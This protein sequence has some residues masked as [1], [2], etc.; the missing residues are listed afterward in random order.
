MDSYGVGRSS[1]RFKALGRLASLTAADSDANKNDQQKIFDSLKHGGFLFREKKTPA[2]NGNKTKALS[3]GNGHIHN[4]PMAS[5]EL[6]VLLALADSVQQLTDASYSVKLLDQL[7]L[8]LVESYHQQLASTAFTRV[9]TPSPWEVLTLKLTLAIIDI[10]EKFTELR[11]LA[12][13]Y[14]NSYLENIKTAVSDE[15]IQRDNAQMFP[16][17]FSLQGFLSAILDRTVYH[18]SPDIQMKLIVSL[19]DIFYSNY[20]LHLE[21]CVSAML[22]VDNSNASDRVWTEYRA[23]YKAAGQILG[24]GLV[25]LRYIETLRHIAGLYLFPSTFKENKA[26][27]SYLDAL[28]DGKRLEQS[29]NELQAKAIKLCCDMA[30][31]EIT[32]L[33]EGTD[34]ADISSPR[35]RRLVFAIKASSLEVLCIATLF[36]LYDVADLMKFIARCLDD[37]DQIIDETLIIRILKIMSLLCR[38]DSDIGGSLTR[39]F[40]RLIVRYGATQSTIQVGTVCVAYALQFLSEDAVISTLY[41]MANVIV[42]IPDVQSDTQRSRSRQLERVTSMGSSIS[43]LSRSE[44]EKSII[45]ENVIH[46]LALVVEH[47]GDNKITALAVSVLSQKIG[48]VNSF[49]DRCIVTG[50]VNLAL[51]GTEKEFR[52][53]LKFYSRLISEAIAKGDV[54][55][56]DAIVDARVRIA[57]RLTQDHPFY[58]MYLKYLLD[59]IVSKGDVHDL[60]HHRIKSSTAIPAEEISCLITPMAKLLPTIQSG[61]PFKSDKVEMLTAFRN[62]WFNMVVHGYWLGSKLSTDKRVDLEVI[63]W[64]SPPLIAEDS[65]D[66]FESVIDVNI[67][68][69]LGASQHELND[70]RQ[71][72]LLAFAASTSATIELRALSYPK[73][74]FLSATVFLESLRASAGDCSKVQLY[75]IDPS[76][77]SGELLRLMSGIMSEVMKRYL[78]RVGQQPDVSTN[79]RISKQLRELLILCCH[80][81]RSVASAAMSS[82]QRIIDAIPSALC[83]RESLFTLLELLTLLWES[84][85]DEDVDQ[86]SPRSVFVSAKANI[87]LELSDSYAHRKAILKGLHEKA[88]TWV[89]SAID[90]TPLDVKGLLQSYLSEMDDLKAFGHLALGRSFAVEMGGRIPRSDNKLVS[91]EKKAEVRIDTLSDFLAQYT[92]RQVYRRS[93]N[94]EMGKIESDFRDIQATLLR[95]NERVSHRKFVSVAELK[96]GLLRAVAFSLSHEFYACELIHYIV[97]IPFGIFS[98]QSIKLGISLWLWILNEAPQY[99]SRV[100]SEIALGF[101][102]SI[103][104]KDGAFSKSHDLIPVLNGKMEYAPSS[105]EDIMHDATIAENKFL[106]HL[107]VVEMIA[108]NFQSSKFRSVHVFEIFERVLRVALLHMP[109]ASF[110]PF[111]RDIR[112]N[113]V[114]FALQ[115]LDSRDFSSQ[116]ASYFKS[117]VFN[118]ALSWF[119]SPPVYPFGGNKLK[120]KTEFRL[121]L[122]VFDS[123]KKIEITEPEKTLLMDLE[124]ELLLQFLENEVYGMAIWLDPLDF[125]PYR[126]LKTYI[127]KKSFEARPEMATAA[128]VIDPALAVSYAARFK[129]D[130]INEELKRLNEKFP[131]GF[132]NNANA[133]PY[134]IEGMVSKNKTAELKYLLYWAPANPIN[135]INYFMPEYSNNTLILQYA[136]RSLESHN[137]DVTFFYV[138]QIVQMLRNDNRGY[139]ERY[140]LETAKLSQL[141]AHQI[142][143]NMNSN[144]YRDEDATKPDPVKPTLDRVLE[145]MKAS[146]SGEDRDFYEREFEF[147]DEV[148][149]ISGK[150]KPYIK[151]TKAE[152][153]IKIDEEM[154]KIKVEVGVYLPSNPDGVVVGIDR[155]SGKPLQSHAKAPFMATFKIRKN[156]KK[157]APIDAEGEEETD[158]GAVE[159]VEQRL[160]AIFKVGDDC[161]QDMLAL[162]LIALFRRIFNASGLDLY[163]FPYRV[164]ATAPG[165]GVID[166]LPNS[167]SRDML[168]REAVNGLYEYFT[169]KHGGEDSIKFQHARNNFVQSMAAYSVISYL[170]QFKDRHNGNI[171]YDDD[172]HILHID[173]GFCFDIV[174]GGVKFEAAPFK[175]THEMVQVMGGSANTQ[176]Y[177][178][179]EE[180]CIKAFLSCRP[181][182]ENIIRCVVPMLESGLPCFKGE[183]TIR[184]LRER[185]VLEKSDKEAAVY[186][187]GLIK[188]SAESV[189]TRGYDEF[190]KMT[191]GIPY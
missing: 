10:G 119:A 7:G 18:N 25:R 22:S 94:S 60:N 32:T 41:T 178:W 90:K 62:A 168:G 148:T 117:L 159:T 64:N 101:E 40:P 158:T 141:F 53:I 81:I 105:K 107:Y 6:E 69:H 31:D 120:L 126:Q 160:S 123:V 138:P 56:K 185:F 48:R 15:S 16:L 114:L 1:I 112:F 98:K 19:H 175:L 80:R 83:N 153:K 92:W 77:R 29:P 154:L 99:Q 58:E 189:Y 166:V 89:Q 122:S 79:V 78:A 144:A 21:Q 169:S 20:S 68:L 96:E 102:W 177:H 86:Y 131:A 156:I 149:S 104:R 151:K 88:I 135:A 146:F 176:A 165:C 34:Y 164:I 70:Q 163:L 13:G 187:R 130:S 74:V 116:R 72:S 162:Q 172:G 125:V 17:T 173:F 100:L 167:I 5:K 84:C 152:K 190:Q 57:S 35:Q 118:A 115:L 37:E 61:K 110:H 133:L 50:L 9:M 54:E 59:D 170:L 129:T 186:M 33:E 161:R 174:P 36:D 82:T 171:M 23:K 44:E 39:I 3:N 24:P 14:I 128:W 140:I 179:F 65:S 188:K 67:I 26:T 124:K 52:Y 66:Q 93:G 27:N 75:L 45:F 76:L 191:N 143:W 8:Y 71:K 28:I 4:I 182:A 150:L 47:Y 113:I 111:V 137:V 132:V 73:Q 103:R 95:M 30:V 183:T 127:P 157:I 109:Q 43:L 145:K 91:L 49:I 180:L 142:I 87:T 55:M 181:Y 147:F 38:L 108:S 85:I 12:G 51:S 139:I 136:M 2:M 46:A 63:A 42:G 11:D 121:L 97:T 106:P 134:L 184:K 155:K